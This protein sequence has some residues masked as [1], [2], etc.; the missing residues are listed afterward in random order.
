MRKV[1]RESNG[2]VIVV[3]EEEISKGIEQVSKSENF[4]LSPEGSAA[5]MSV[6]QLIEK[7]IIS[8]DDKIVFLNTGSNLESQ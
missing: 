2:E 7:K 1:I 4:Q 3:T 6:S 5:W 8:T